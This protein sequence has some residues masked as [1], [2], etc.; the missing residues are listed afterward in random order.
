MIPPAHHPRWRQVRM[1][2]YMTS[3]VH[4]LVLSASPPRVLM[5]NSWRASVWSLLQGVLTCTCWTCWVRWR[6]R[7]RATSTSWSSRRKTTS[8]ICS[9]SQRW[10]GAQRNIMSKPSSIYVPV[11]CIFLSAD[12]SQAS[13][14]LWAADGEGSGHDLRQ[15]EGAHH[16]QHQ[17]A[18]VK[19]NMHSYMTWRC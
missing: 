12:L 11:L 10:T 14:G 4:L 9:W 16:V 1:S 7:G 19:I 5:C 3:D 17:T 13:A 6:G 2:S 18:Q 15:L 8:T